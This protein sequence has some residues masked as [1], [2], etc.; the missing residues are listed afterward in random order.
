MIELRN[1]TKSFRTP[2]G[3]KY[4]A[5]RINAVFPTGKAVALM[6]RNGA[7]KSTLL[8]MISGS[9]RHDS[10]QIVTAGTVSFPVGFAGTFHRDLTG[11]QNCRFIAR[12]YGVDTGELLDFV[13]DFSALGGHFN[14]P[15]RSYSSGM[16][17]RLAFGISMGIHFDTYLVDE[18]TSVGDRA[19]RAKSAEMFKARLATRSAIVVTHSLAEVRNLCNAGAILENGTLSFFEDVEEAIARHLKNMDKPA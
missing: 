4:V 12:I 10:G 3:R 6:G 14:M 16:R 15:V 8:Q 5:R 9:M 17:S 13:A 18:V 11:A 19:F 1:L 2:R 7:G